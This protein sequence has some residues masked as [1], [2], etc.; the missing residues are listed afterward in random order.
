MAELVVTLLLC[1]MRT[2]PA[3]AGMVSEQPQFPHSPRLHSCVQER[4]G[5]RRY[6]SWRCG[7]EGQGN[8]GRWED[9]AVLRRGP[10]SPCHA[11]V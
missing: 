6:Y 7:S 1:G 2:R 8:V 10:P 3:V 9:R 5:G 4:P 11:T